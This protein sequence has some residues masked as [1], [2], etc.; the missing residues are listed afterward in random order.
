MENNSNVNHYQNDFLL[1]KTSQTVTITR[2][3]DAALEQ[4]WNAFTT[5]EI[6]DQWVAP[7]PF[8]S[9]TKYMD[10]TVGGRRFYAMISPDGQ[11][12]WILQRY[13]A[14][15]P[16]SNFKLFNTFADKDETPEITGSE[17]DYTFI[18]Y[19]QQTVVRIVIYN[20]SLER[21]ERMIEF[22]FKEGYTMSMENLENV[23]SLNK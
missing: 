12:R 13:L 16:L 17:W 11:E 14:I 3:F 1:D 21:M 4:V 9:K 18:E 23:L 5:A 10:F 8:T 15:T 2:V 19:N 22:G 20:E 7:K 6:L